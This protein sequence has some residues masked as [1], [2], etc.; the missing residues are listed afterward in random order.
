MSEQMLAYR[1]PALLLCAVLN[2][3]SIVGKIIAAL[4]ASREVYT[5]SAREAH[6]E[7]THEQ[8]KAENKYD[9]RGLE[10]GYLA[11]GQSRQAADV[12]QAIQ[13]YELLPVRDFAAQDPI[14]IGAVVELEREGE[15]AVYFVGPL[16]GGIE[17][18]C[19]GRSVQVIT[20][21]SPMGLQLVGH[22]QGA[23]L[24]IKVGGASESYR[25]VAVI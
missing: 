19:E 6:A 3:Q 1:S 25:I 14:D 24:S 21:N 7:A 18:E 9:T 5:H 17:I 20:P 15:R 13:R 8:N 11:R 12:T 2:K 16:A 23:R 10:A 22:K 4:S